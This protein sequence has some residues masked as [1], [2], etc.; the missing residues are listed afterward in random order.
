MLSLH[1]FESGAMYEQSLVLDESQWLKLAVEDYWRGHIVQLPRQILNE[2]LCIWQS[3][4]ALQSALSSLLY[5]HVTPLQK[6]DIRASHQCVD[7]YI[8][9]LQ[10]TKRWWLDNNVAQQIVDAD[11]KANTKLGKADYIGK[12]QA[13]CLSDESRADFDKDLWQVFSPAKVAGAM[14]KTSKSL[15]HLDFSRFETLGYLQQQC[16]EQLLLA[17]SLDALGHISRN[18]ALS[19]I[20]I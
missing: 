2:L 13:F 7:E 4:Q 6:A 20:H 14:K 10:E 8:R 9:T 19:L 11:L 3:P 5:R 16:H 1:A 17:Y 15:A 12:M 18:L